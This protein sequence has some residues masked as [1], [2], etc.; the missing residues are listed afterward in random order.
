MVD[1]VFIGANSA[2]IILDNG[3]GN[4][5]N[6][7]VTMDPGRNGMVIGGM[8]MIAGRIGPHG[9]NSRNNLIRIRS[10]LCTSG[11]RLIY[12]GYNRTAHMNRGSNG[13]IYGG[14]GYNG[15]F[16]ME[17]SRGGNYGVGED[18]WRQDYSYVSRRVSVQ[19]YCTG[20]RT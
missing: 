1:G 20:P 18:L 9:V 13:H 11:I 16:W 17:R 2:M 6:R 7:I 3:S 14:S 12:P 4:I 15:R 19:L 8:G 5:G 10:T